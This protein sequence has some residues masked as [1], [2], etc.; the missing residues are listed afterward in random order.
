M[1]DEA[2][3]IFRE[4]ECVTFCIEGVPLDA[5]SCL[6]TV[7]KKCWKY[8]RNMKLLC[9]CVR[10]F[11]S[12]EYWY[13]MCHLLNWRSAFRCSA[14]LPQN[15]KKTVLKMWLHC[16]ITVCFW[17]PNSFV[18]IMNML[19][20]ELKEC[21]LMQNCLTKI[22][23]KIQLQ[24]ENTVWLRK[25]KSF[26]SDYEYRICRFFNWRRMKW[27]LMKSCLGT[28][29]KQGWNYG[30]NVKILCG[31]E[32]RTFLS[33]EYWYWMCHVIISHQNDLISVKKY[34]FRFITSPMGNKIT[35]VLTHRKKFPEMGSYCHEE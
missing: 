14:V 34:L 16:K 30:C 20:F 8:G 33:D 15:C 13:W 28:V 31:W 12:D 19:P 32:R 5:E 7:R 2:E 3:N 9:G 6:K 29:R 25:P 26:F 11:L 22:V 27:L 17:K 24:C 4:Y 18:E 23:L 21:I 10:K 35:I 1:S